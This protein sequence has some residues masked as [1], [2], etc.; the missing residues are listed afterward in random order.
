MGGRDVT[1]HLMTLLRRAGYIFHTTAEFEIVKKIKEKY[2]FV[3]PMTALSDEYKIQDE[4]SQTSYILPDGNIMKIASEKFQAP[5][6][7]FQPDKIGLEYPGIHEMVI[8]AIKK[9]DIDLRKT[10][11]NSIVIAGGTT[12]FTGFGDRLHKSIQ[13][14]SP[15]DMKVTLIAPNNRKFSCWIGGATV[16]SLKAFNRMWVTKKE[17]EEEGIRVLL[18]KNF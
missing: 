7:L 18:N 1:H 10:L 17:M 15:K 14:L 9:C 4:K 2:C 12:L 8:D 6:I 16:S 3:A 11:Y 5:E 13:K